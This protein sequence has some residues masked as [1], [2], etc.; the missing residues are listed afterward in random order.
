MVMESDFNTVT[1][2]EKKKIPNIGFHINMA[3]MNLYS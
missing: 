1:S 3:D 2:S